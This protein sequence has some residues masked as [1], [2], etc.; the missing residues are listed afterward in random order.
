MAD[1][2][3]WRSAVLLEYVPKRVERLL[4]AESDL[5]RIDQRNAIGPHDIILGALGKRRRIMSVECVL[6]AAR[7]DDDISGQLTV[8]THS[9]ALLRKPLIRL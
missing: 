5:G 2:L 8:V 9:K 1:D 6:C 3:K 4:S 7:I